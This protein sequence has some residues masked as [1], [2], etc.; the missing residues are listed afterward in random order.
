LAALTCVTML[1]ISS[2]LRYTP[3][4]ELASPSGFAVPQMS[5]LAV[6]AGI[7]LFVM[8]SVCLNILDWDMTGGD[9]RWTWIS[10]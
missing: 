7:C 4:Y 5:V 1:A 3:L 8:R 9:P 10:A 6:L 2:L